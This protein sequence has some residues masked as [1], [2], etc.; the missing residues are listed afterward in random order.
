MVLVVLFFVLSFMAIGGT[1][2]NINPYDNLIWIK[3]IAHFIFLAFTMMII[4][5]C[6]KKFSSKAN[7]K[8]GRRICK[9]NCLIVL[10]FYFVIDIFLMSGIYD[11][12]FENLGANLVYALMFL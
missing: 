5:F 7:V 2:L 11:E 10:S 9:W 1:Y 3:T 12:T 6:Y 4:P 8:N